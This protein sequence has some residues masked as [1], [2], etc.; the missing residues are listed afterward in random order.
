MEEEKPYS[1]PFFQTFPLPP[2]HHGKMA[3]DE[4]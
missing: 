2:L 3:E 4:R 1:F